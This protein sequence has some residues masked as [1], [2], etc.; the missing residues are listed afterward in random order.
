LGLVEGVVELVSILKVD[1]GRRRVVGRGVEQENRDT[2]GMGS[3]G[4]VAFIRVLYESLHDVAALPPTPEP[5]A[6]LV[7]RFF[8]LTLCPAVS[9]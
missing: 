4:F 9:S 8:D 2:L 7:T 5:P 3:G 6:G 1:C